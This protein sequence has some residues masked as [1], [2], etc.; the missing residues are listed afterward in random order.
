VEGIFRIIVEF[1]VIGKQ[2]WHSNMK[3][4]RFYANDE[5]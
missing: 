1:W 2:L 5:E 4:S 3:K